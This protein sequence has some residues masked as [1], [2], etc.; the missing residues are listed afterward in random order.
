VTGPFFQG[1]KWFYDCFKLVV[2]KQGCTKLWGLQSNIADEGGHRAAL[3]DLHEWL[4]FVSSF[5]DK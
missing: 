4:E 3:K 5:M 2:E 1:K